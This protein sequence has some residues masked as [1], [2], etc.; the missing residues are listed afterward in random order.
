MS[1]LHTLHTGIKMEVYFDDATDKYTTGYLD[2]SGNERSS[3]ELR[4]KRNT[5][6]YYTIDR[7]SMQDI[8][9]T[10]NV[11]VLQFKARMLTHEWAD[12]DAMMKAYYTAAKQAIAALEVKVNVPKPGYSYHRKVL[13]GEDHDLVVRAISGTWLGDASETLRATFNLLL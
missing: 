3:T 2:F 13:V 8:A 6:A 11:V 10:L 7:K 12:A 4:H 5:S 9:D 1:T